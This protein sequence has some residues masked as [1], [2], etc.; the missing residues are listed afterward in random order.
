MDT[1]HSNAFGILWVKVWAQKHNPVKTIYKLMTNGIKR[2]I[3]P[4]Q[5]MCCTW[6]NCSSFC[7]RNVRLQVA[8]SVS[9]ITI[10]IK[11]KFIRTILVIWHVKD[12][13]NSVYLTFLQTFDKPF[14]EARPYFSI[15]QKKLAWDR[16]AKRHLL[17]W[18]KF[19]LAFTI[20]LGTKKKPNLFTVEWC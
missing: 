18:S 3:L 11:A 6:Q 17:F 4:L 20:V 16:N 15:V 14:E 1:K 9:S 7:T 19:G 10:A 12:I 13:W 8:S 5:Q 2:F